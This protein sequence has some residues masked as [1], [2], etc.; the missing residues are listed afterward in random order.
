M[1]FGRLTVTNIYKTVNKSVVWLCNC[2]CGK[3]RYVLR[4]TLLNGDTM[5]CGCLK[6]QRNWAWRGHQEI[7]GAYWTNVKGNAKKR[8]L[9]VE[10]TIQYAWEIFIIQDRR[11]FFSGVELKFVQNWTNKEEQ[12]TASLDR[13]D[14]SLGY[15]VGNI[16]WV[17]KIINVMR[18][19][20]KDDVFVRWCKL[21]SENRNIPTEANLPILEAQ[22]FNK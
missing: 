2:D 11:C 10:I 19:R 4:K 9:A 6:K 22:R 18:I 20:L 15:I 3:E 7:S 17:H 8:D 14:T 1:R 12:Q 5:S 16:R 13:I 21:V